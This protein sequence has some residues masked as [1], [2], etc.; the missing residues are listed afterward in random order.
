MSRE[1]EINKIAEEIFQTAKSKGWH[2]EG[3]D[4]DFY[5]AKT[6]ANIHGEISEFWEAHRKD[7]LFKQCDK[8]CELTCGEE[9]LADIVIRVL[10]TA[11]KLNIDIGRAIV[12]KMAF[13]KTRTHRH[14]GK[15]A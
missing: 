2:L 12:T 7:E 3:E 5:I 6:S 4:I 14:G 15:K 8:D 1:H 9:E 11:R 13:N 10:D